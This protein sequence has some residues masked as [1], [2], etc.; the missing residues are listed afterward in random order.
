[1]NSAVDTLPH[2]ANL[3]LWKKHSNS[4]CP[5]CGERQTLIHILNACKVA[6]DQRRYNHHHDA[7]LSLIVTFLTDKSKPTANLTSDLG[8]YTFPQHIVTTDLRPDI[9]W[10]DDSLKKI[11]LIEL[12]VCF[13]SSFLHASERKATKYEDVMVRARASGYSGQVI[14]LEVGSRGIVGE[15]GFSCLKAEFNI[16][17]RELSG[18]R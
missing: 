3:H 16:K 18:S 10:W 17:E 1:M 14:T 12:T 11:L 6:L 7:I 5:L 15:G 13:E 2:K 4:S 9:V 8:A